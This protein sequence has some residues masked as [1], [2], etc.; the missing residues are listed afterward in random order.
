MYRLLISFLLFVISFSCSSNDE[1][2]DYLIRVGTDKNSYA[3]DT[4]TTIYLYVNNG[5]ELPV[6]FQCKGVIMLYEY[7]NGNMNNSWTVHGFEYCGVS[8]M[9]PSSSITIDLNFLKWKDM[10]DAKFNE[11]V[12][13]NLDFHL[14]RDKKVKQPLNNGNQISNYFKIIRE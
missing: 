14:Y 4:S 11:T 9:T 2:E 13:Y 6:Y 7:E 1:S 3:A 8:T 10:P 12:I 5:G